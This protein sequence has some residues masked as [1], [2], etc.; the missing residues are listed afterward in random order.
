[1]PAL[2]V[3]GCLLFASLFFVPNAGAITAAATGTTGKRADAGTATAKKSKKSTPRATRTSSPKVTTPALTQAGQSEARLLAIYQLIGQSKTRQAL[4]QAQ[5]L[6]NEHPNFQL[7]QLVLGDLL[8]AHVRPL[9]ALGDVPDT[10]AQVGASVLNELREESAQRLKALRE[11][12]PAGSIPTAFVSL[13]LRNRHAIAIDASRSRLYLFEN[14]ASGI[15]LIA[16]YYI[17]L[18]KSGIEKSAEGDLRTPLGVYFV[19]S[20][21]DPKSLK[22]FYGAGALPINYPNPYDVRRGKTGSGI[23]LHGTPPNQFSRAPRATDGCVVLAN[24]DLSHIV[25]TVEIRTTPVVIAQTLSWTA[26]QNL[27]A[28]SRNFEITLDAWRRAKVSGNLER[29]RSFYTTDFSGN[30]RPLAEW[31]PGLQRD[32]ARIAGKDLLLKDLSLLRYPEV[33][34]TMVVTF[35]EVLSG[36][37]TGVIRRQYWSRMPDGSGHSWKI[38]F[39]GVIG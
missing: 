22:D 1:M 11:R 36:E 27:V 14:S 10:A 18:G 34:E 30:G 2:F 23:W 20:N 32:L 13:S 17:S 29:V 5:A 8:S 38:F 24:P 31:L 16:D 25:K 35:G 9:R 7:A 4:I 6:V 21:L 28:P 39:E 26:P 15:K 33:Q 12:P 37:R 3:S 19:S